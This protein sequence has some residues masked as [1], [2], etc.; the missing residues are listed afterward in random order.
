MGAERKRIVLTKRMVAVA[1]AAVMV[2]LLAACGASEPEAIGDAHARMPASSRDLEGENYGDVVAVLEKAGFTAVET[3][4]LGDLITGWVNKPDTVDE[5]EID[6]V[7]SFD[8]GDVFARDVRIVVNY[9]SFPEDSESPATSDAD[10]GE[11]EVDL[12]YWCDRGSFGKVADM[13]LRYTQGNIPVTIKV[14]SPV[15]LSSPTKQG[16]NAVFQVTIT[17]MS[18]T[19]TWDPTLRSL[20]VPATDTDTSVINYGEEPTGFAGEDLAPLQSLSFSDEW[21]VADLQDVRYELR[22]DG[23][24]GDTVCFA[25]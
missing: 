1:V 20:A 16:A 21:A 9:H 6:G 23:L 4:A 19:R 25:R 10:P 12:P 8:E 7:T 5:V 14:E 2:V 18:D 24:A 3:T 22:V 15:P 17:N 11:A 13:E